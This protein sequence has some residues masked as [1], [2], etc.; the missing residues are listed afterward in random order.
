MGIAR[1][2]LAIVVVISHCGIYLNV[3]NIGVYSVV[4]FYMISGYYFN[5]TWNRLYNGT[6]KRTL[7]KFYIDRLLR[8][9]P[10]YF[11][12]LGLSSAVVI[13]L[14]INNYF[15]S[16]DLNAISILSNI[17]IFP[18]NYYM[19]SGIDRMSI[20]PQAWSLGLEL[21]F[22]LSF[23]FLMR[24]NKILLFTFIISIFIATNAYLGVIARDWYSY[25]LLP[26]VIY[27]FIIG[28]ALG[29]RDRKNELIYMSIFTLISFL[30]IATNNLGVHKD[31]TI[32]SIGQMDY[33]LEII[34]GVFSGYF[35]IKI[36]SSIRI[37]NKYKNLDK[38]FAELSYPIYLT[39]FIPI[40]IFSDFNIGL[41]IFSVIFLT[42]IISIPVLIISSK[43]VKR[44]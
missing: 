7:V 28:H 35:L 42:I 12:C 36:F 43:F 38:F 26:G 34:S 14:N 5:V 1:F 25:R 32:E 15:L 17:T 23:P 39:H 2:I 30:L 9:Y 4:I 3:Y 11:V 8:I 44:Y 16:G 29:S 10:T 13:F 20:I 22:Y 33:S 21:T 24:N 18:L 6:F 27:I 40:W 19:Y 37:N 41:S 31:P